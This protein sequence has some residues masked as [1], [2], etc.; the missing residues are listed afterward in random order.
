MGWFNISERVEAADGR[1]GQVAGIT[2]HDGQQ[3]IKVE[4]DDGRRTGWLWAS[5]FKGEDE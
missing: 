4:Y 5:Q 1:T 2:N 3:V